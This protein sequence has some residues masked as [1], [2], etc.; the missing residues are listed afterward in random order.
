[1]KQHYPDDQAYIAVN[2]QF[3]DDL[4][5]QSNRLAVFTI[6]SYKLSLIKSS[7]NPSPEEMTEK[8]KNTLLNYTDPVRVLAHTGFF[9]A[10]LHN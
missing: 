1:M 7:F 5:T 10:E 9:E 6:N 3:I 4:V 2:F 8:I